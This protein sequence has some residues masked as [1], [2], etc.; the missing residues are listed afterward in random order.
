MAND[1]RKYHEGATTRNTNALNDTF[2]AGRSTAARPGS[3]TGWSA[4][5]VAAL[6]SGVS[7]RPGTRH[8]YLYSIPAGIAEIFSRVSMLRPMEVGGGE[9]GTQVGTVPPDGP[10]FHQAALEEDLCP[11][12]ISSREKSVSPAGP[13]TFAGIGGGILVTPDGYPDQY[14]EPHHQDKDCG[15]SPPRRK[16]CHLLVQSCVLM[17]HPTLPSNSL[18]LRMECHTV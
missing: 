1:A 5:F 8:G 4:R 2:R 9:I 16:R 15:I 10:V 12:M 11:A 13:A 17:F 7:P 6:P 3:C 18:R 14:R